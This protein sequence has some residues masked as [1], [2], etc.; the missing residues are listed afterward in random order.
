M[1]LID[2]SYDI[3][4]NVP[5]N[6]DA[7]VPVIEKAGRTCYKSD[8][9]ITPDSAEQFVTKI[10]KSGHLSV[11]EHSNLVFRYKVR[12]GTQFWNTI[13]DRFR[14]YFDSKWIYVQYDGN[15]YIYVY[16]NW[17]AFYEFINEKH[18]T[19]DLT[20]AVAIQQATRFFNIEG[21]EPVL[22]YKDVPI[23]AHRLSVKII[24][25]RAVLAEI[26]RHRDDVGFSVE[27]Q[28][29]CEY[30]T[31]KH[32][33][34]KYIKPWF[35]DDMPDDQKD[36]VKQSLMIAE[37]QYRRCVLEYKMS[38]QKSRYVLPNATAVEL[39]MTA[40]I[41]QWMHMFSLR[42]A[43]GAYPPMRNLMNGLYDD[44]LLTSQFKGK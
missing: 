6:Y 19:S 32:G 31:K 36:S 26:T 33:E 11:I 8:D 35:Y 20:L 38:A 1:E 28:R 37:E 14:S 42:R 22:D 34:L 44:M 30:C 13:Y 29:Y 5:L 23:F 4:G 27:S 18:K 12:Q 21:L 40:Y 43:K 17:R 41:P 3:L 39:I 9:K 15:D 25:D 24:T 2:Q 10:T 16:G 7:G